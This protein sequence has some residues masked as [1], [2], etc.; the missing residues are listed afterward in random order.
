MSNLISKQDNTKTQKPLIYKKIPYKS[1][2]YYFVDLGGKPSP[3]ITPQQ[4]WNRQ[5]R[6][7]TWED[8]K[9]LLRGINNTFGKAASLASFIYGGGWAATRLLNGNK[10]SK[11]GQVLSKYVLPTNTID[12]IGDI[13][14]L[15]ENPSIS[16]VT[17]TGVSLGLGR[18]K[19][20]GK[21]SRQAAELGSQGL[22]LFNSYQEG[23][24]ITLDNTKVQKPIVQ[25]FFPAK[26]AT[27]IN[28][29]Y[30]KRNRFYK[31]GNLE[32]VSPEFDLIGLAS[33]IKNL[34]K[35]L[36]VSK[37]L[38]PET[39]NLAVKVTP[40][41]F[42]SKDVVP[43]STLKF[44]NPIKSPVENFSYIKT[45]MPKGVSGGYNPITNKVRISNNLNP[46]QEA[47]TK[48]HEFR[49]R[50]DT[51]YKLNIPQE[52]LLKSYKIYSGIK[53]PASK[54]V[55]EK[56]TT[57]TE[58]RY[59][60]FNEFTNKYGRTPTISELNKYIDSMPVEEL[61]SRLSRVNGYGSDYVGAFSKWLKNNSNNTRPEDL[62]K[63]I[64]TWNTNIKSAL[65]YVPVGTGAILVPKNNK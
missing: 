17:E 35:L 41:E 60:L 12:A 8:T 53:H 23:G 21:V 47:S 57:N 64:D 16:N 10:S 46:L 43:R 6:E 50:L 63:M 7:R 61:S 40:E 36:K 29:D 31:K 15:I 65:K 13:S 28:Q 5:K 27:K 2:Q 52:N 49:H 14:Q 18:W 4:R 45:S 62:N 32:I 34:G 44:N 58:L 38:S 51:K 20:F 11:I 54:T 26:G 39:S 37:S 55:A 48:V 9:N 33:G 19:D 1:R 22:N 3:D 42:Y 24:I 59:N 56:M 30:L 25:K